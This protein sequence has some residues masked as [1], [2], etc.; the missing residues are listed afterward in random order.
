MEEDRSRRT[1]RN[2]G[3]SD[4]F[5]VGAAWSPDTMFHVSATGTLLQPLAGVRF[6]TP[7]T[8]SIPVAKDF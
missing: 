4:G 8:V 6:W 5:L 2:V 3:E 7:K 1:R